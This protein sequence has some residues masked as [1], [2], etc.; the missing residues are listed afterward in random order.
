M[1]IQWTAA[2]ESGVRE[3]DDQH[4][5][6]FQ[7]MNGFFDA[8]M[9]KKSVVEIKNQFQFLEHYVNTHFAWEERFMLLFKY[10]SYEAHKAQHDE[11]AGG[12]RTLENEFD[13]SGPTEELL[14]SMSRFLINWLLGHIHGFD[15][16]LGAFLKKET[17]KAGIASND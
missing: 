2:L 7:C 3:I 8:W 9:G 5:Q 10:P 11:L 16:A 4:M 6:L 13:T 15:I 14:D 17:A 1:P 12:F